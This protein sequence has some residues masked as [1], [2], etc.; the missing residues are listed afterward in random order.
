MLQSLQ[1]VQ[2][3]HRWIRKIH[4][5]WLTLSSFWSSPE[6]RCLDDYGTMR[7]VAH[8]LASNLTSSHLHH[9]Y[10]GRAVSWRAGNSH[11]ISVFRFGYTD[12]LRRRLQFMMAAWWVLVSKV[13]AK[14]PRCTERHAE[15]PQAYSV[16]CGDCQN[17]FNRALFTVSP[18]FQE[19]F[20]HFATG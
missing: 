20:W 18:S 7:T 5:Q 19:V 9:T 15:M 12:C 14:H 2:K 17:A 3:M 11:V 10:H 4:C 13:I 8:I 6:N 16:S 1:S